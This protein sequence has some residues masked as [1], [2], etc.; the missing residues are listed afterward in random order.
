MRVRRKNANQRL[1]VLFGVLAAA[2]YTLVFSQSTLAQQSQVSTTICDTQPPTISITQP[3]EGAT[4]ATST[5]A[6]QGSIERAS[7]LTLQ[8]NGTTVTTIPI[9][10]SSNFNIPLTLEEGSNVIELE[11]QF[12]C[13]DTNA[14]ESVTVQYEPSVTPPDPDPEQPGPGGGGTSPGDTG[15]GFIPGVPITGIGPI[16]DRIKDNLSGKPDDTTGE[17]YERSYVV[18]VRSW[19][20]SVL[21]VSLLIAALLPRHHYRRIGKRLGFN[22]SN[23]VMALL[24][25]RLI[26]LTSAIVALITLQL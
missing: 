2:V 23:P 9:S 8:R 14:S 10:F 25:F 1:T 6:V 7:S 12:T 3:L 26:F 13:N 22:V 24:V 17:E 5:I 16:I 11:A 19:L 18:L 20:A 4:L 15:G 21:G